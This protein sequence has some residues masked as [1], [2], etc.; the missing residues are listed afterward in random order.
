MADDLDCAN[1]TI[2]PEVTAC[3]EQMWQ[4]ADEDLNLAYQLARSTALE[5]DDD[6]RPGTLPLTSTLLRDAQRQWIVYRDDACEAE[7]M[8]YRGGSGQP[9]A[10]YECLTR[11]TRERTEHLRFFGEQN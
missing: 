2:Q 5:L 4:F 10:Y 11:L 9:Q 6:L 1:P 3:A 8:L 7:S